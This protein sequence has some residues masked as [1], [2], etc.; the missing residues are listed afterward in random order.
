MKPRI[1]RIRGDEKYFR[2]M[3]KGV[4]SDGVEA[5]GFGHTIEQAYAEWLVY[6]ETDIPF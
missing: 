3:C 2:F 4:R 6:D 1:V 5:W